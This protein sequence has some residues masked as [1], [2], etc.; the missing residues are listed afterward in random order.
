MSI[1]K[2]KEI[3]GALD[4]LRGMMANCEVQAS[5][6]NELE[7]IQSRLSA[8]IKEWEGHD[9]G[10]TRYCPECGL[11]GKVGKRFVDCCPDGDKARRVPEDIAI[12]AGAG[13]AVLYPR[14]SATD[15]APPA[16]DKL[17]E[18]LR[19][20]HSACLAGD[21]NEHWDEY[22]QASEALASYKQENKP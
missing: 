22:K 15:A 9:T 6:N 4:V 8:V 17:V 5:L 16:V 20:L 2:L 12:Q 10:M 18:A 7:R 14:S 11:V 1:E 19:L 13:F 3:D 21:F